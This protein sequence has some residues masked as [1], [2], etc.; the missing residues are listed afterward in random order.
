MRQR[1]LTSRCR[2]WNVNWVPKREYLNGEI[3]NTGK[4]TVI[5]SN[6]SRIILRQWWQNTTSD[7]QDYQWGT[8][9][10]HKETFYAWGGS[11]LF[12]GEDQ[13]RIGCWRRQ[14]KDKLLEK[15]SVGFINLRLQEDYVQHFI[16]CK[17]WR[18]VLGGGDVVIKLWIQNME[19]CIILKTQKNSDAWRDM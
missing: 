5:K 12:N 3:S 16:G 19:F 6:S 4:G 11:T 1:F 2:H 10:R 15:K 14:V 8:E 7:C 17:Y 18:V 13:S 9:R